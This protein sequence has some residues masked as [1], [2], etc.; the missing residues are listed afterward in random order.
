MQYLLR[1]DQLAFE[2]ID[3]YIHFILNALDCLHAAA[4]TI[5]L[6]TNCPMTFATNSLNRNSYTVYTYV[7]KLHI[8]IPSVSPLV[9][10]QVFRNRSALERMARVASSACRP[11]LFAQAPRYLQTGSTFMSEEATTSTHFGR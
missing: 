2:L 6:P 11:A 4:T 8:D 9:V 3:H 10:M 1:P 7:F 5:G